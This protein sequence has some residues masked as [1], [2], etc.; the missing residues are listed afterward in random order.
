MKS[1]L[2]KYLIIFLA[3][4]FAISIATKAVAKSAQ[5]QS[6]TIQLVE[7]AEQLYRAEQYVKAGQVWQQAVTAFGQQSDVLN[8]AMALSNL[9]LTQQELGNLSAAET[10]SIS[11]LELL[12]TQ[13]DTPPQQRLLANSLDVK[14]SIARSLGKSKIAVETWQ[15][16]EAIYREL[17]ENEAIIQNQINQAQAL[18]D[19][20]YYRRAGKILS[21]LQTELNNKPDSTAKVSALLGLGNTLRAVGNLEGSQ[22]SLGVL[23]QALEIAETNSDEQKDAVLL[24]LGNTFRALGNRAEQSQTIQQADLYSSQCSVDSNLEVAEY[25]RQAADF[26]QR[27][28][29]SADLSTK[30]KA[31]LN[32]LSLQIQNQTLSRSNSKRDPRLIADIK[33]NLAHLPVTRSTVYDR[34]NLVQSL[35][36]LQPNTVE[37]PS[38]MVQ[39]CPS[40]SNF[41]VSWGQ[42]ESEVKIALEQAN[43]LEDKPAIAYASGYLGTVYQQTG[44]LTQA[45]RLTEQAL[46]NINSDAIDN[47]ASPE[48]AYLWQWQ[49]GRIYRL[50]NELKGALQAYNSAFNTLQSLNAN[51][52]AVNPEVQFAFRNQ[53]EPLY[54]ERAALLLA[55]PQPS[56]ENLVLARDTIEALQLAQLNNFFH[57]ACL[58]A[59]PQKIEQLDPAAA[60][61]YSI[62]LPDRLAIILSQPQQPLK[63]YQTAIEPQTIDRALEDLYATFSR[64]APSK[65]SQPNRTFYNWLVRPFE[66]EFAANQTNTL[67]FILDGIMKGIP[68]AALHDGKRYLIEKY[69]LALTPGL[70]LLT[71]GSLTSDTLK[72][73]TGGLTESRQGFS[74]LP[75]VEVEVSEIADLVP[76]EILL[77]KNFT[78]DLLRE[79]ITTSPYPIVHLATH[80]Q[81]S[82]RAEDTFLLTWDDRINVKYLDR[83]LQDRDFA[84]DTPVEL[85]ILSACQTATGDKQAALGLAGVAVRSG[86]RSTLATLW[87]IQDNSTAELM[88]EFYRAIKKP[89]TTK[90]EALRQAQLSLLRSPKYQH[91]YYWSAFVLVGNWL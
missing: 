19:L 25:Y 43:Q 84:E 70:Q 29:K 36:Y 48:V 22:G 15:Q 77:D 8:Q 6:D 68:V 88:I 3:L 65:P 2:D 67:V 83:L 16:A 34:L 59:Q 50:Q 51:L 64:I 31:Q 53:I 24:S 72:T 7:Q 87:S 42:I 56:Q 69:G 27:S 66:P 80:G 4:I 30:N 41:E 91:P 78:R 37:F 21:S 75:Y 81:F 62:I 47:T 32:L 49:L 20:G 90:A 35:I 57:E 60:I 40:S 28:A 73:I 86:A 11:S 76:S 39:Q 12:Q 63:Y 9:A 85:L 1:L 14:G 74:S 55:D 18:Q 23:Q 45:R 38:P 46:L 17:N 58:D 10:A 44:K 13:S 71:S 61:I 33:T 26:Y 54:R 79:Q 82:S 52:V 89:G 5:V